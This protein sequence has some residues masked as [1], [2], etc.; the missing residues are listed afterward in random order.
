[1]VGICWNCNKVHPGYMVALKR[2]HCRAFN[3]K[4]IKCNQIEHLARCC[5]NFREPRSKV[6]PVNVSF[7]MKEGAI[8]EELREATGEK[9]GLDSDIVHMGG[10]D[11][12][13]NF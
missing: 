10:P 7:I 5:G 4:C 13:Q 1:M 6:R 3:L 11:Q 12:F 8:E 9:K 2:I